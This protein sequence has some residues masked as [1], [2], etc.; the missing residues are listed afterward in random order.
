M[1]LKSTPIL[2]LL[3]VNKTKLLELGSKKVLSIESL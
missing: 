1:I 2:R 3:V